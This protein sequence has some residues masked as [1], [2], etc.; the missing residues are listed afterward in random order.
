MPCCHPS[1]F[2]PLLLPP[3]FL[4]LF[5]IRSGMDA[6]FFLCWFFSCLPLLLLFLILFVFVNCM[7]KA[8]YHI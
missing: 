7:T 3:L 8:N 1:P 4:L 5:M 6:W 2:A